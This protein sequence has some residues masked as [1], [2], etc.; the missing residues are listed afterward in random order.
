M[1]NQ[2]RGSNIVCSNTPDGELEVGCVMWMMVTIYAA[3]RDI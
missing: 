1:I 3:V 2:A